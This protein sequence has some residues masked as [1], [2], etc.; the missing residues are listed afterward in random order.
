M[1]FRTIGGS[2]AVAGLGA[3][4]NNRLAH[5]DSLPDA[6]ATVYTVLIPLAV[7]G[8]LC[9]LALEDRPLSSAS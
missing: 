5:G 1:F 7:V 4:L 2:F 9:A 3:L 8:V 6:L